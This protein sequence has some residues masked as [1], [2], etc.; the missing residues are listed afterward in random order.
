MET[1]MDK[2]LGL[3]L[4]GTEVT[5]VDDEAALPEHGQV[6]HRIVGVMTDALQQGMPPLSIV[7]GAVDAL[8]SLIGQSCPAELQDRITDELSERLHTGTRRVREAAT[9]IDPNRPH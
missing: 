5:A 1:D 8:S 2:F 6:A 9:Q 7:I 4:D 3:Q